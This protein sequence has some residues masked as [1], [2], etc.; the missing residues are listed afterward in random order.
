MMLKKGIPRHSQISQ[1]LRNQIDKGVYEADE[2]LPSE[3][4]LAKK[5]DVSRVTIRRAL[6]SLE[7]ESIIYRCQ[8]LGSFV[9]DE[10]ASHDLVKLTD[11]NED[12]AK[13]GLEPSSVVKKFETVDAPDWLV[14]L[15]N[16]DEG[17][18]VLQIDRLRLGDDEPIAFDSTWLPILYGQLL[19][20]KKLTESTIYNLLEKNYDIPV[21]RGCYRLSA[22]I[23]DENLADVLKVD[24]NS[25]LFV[26]DRLSYT[27]GEKPLYYQKRYYRNDKVV[28]E[29]TLERTP[30]NQFGNMPLKEFIPVF[31]SI[32][33]STENT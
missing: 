20:K 16:I 31:S 17:S 19:D 2:K 26:I 21:I 11:F 18:K 32:E 28:Y 22:E 3:N 1:W 9:S 7:N 15:L 25:P 13:A 24:E 29:M 10:R 4:E 33:K 6:Q 8:G 5:F 27:I 12:M 30:G 23:A 14:S